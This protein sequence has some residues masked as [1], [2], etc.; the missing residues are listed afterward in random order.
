MNCGIVSYSF[1]YQ[2]S[3]L[4]IW[5]WIKRGPPLLRIVS[6]TLPYALVQTANAFRTL[7]NNNH[8]S[9]NFQRVKQLQHFGIT[10]TQFP[11]YLINISFN[12]LSL[13][14]SFINI[15]LVRQTCAVSVT[16]M[17]SLPRI[18]YS[19]NQTRINM[20]NKFVIRLSS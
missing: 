7:P 13:Y 6:G 2:S 3:D 10:R 17:T 12:N 11:L 14:K 19:L 1:K 15:S 20:K 16:S 8:P 4:S 18:S 5:Y 9:L